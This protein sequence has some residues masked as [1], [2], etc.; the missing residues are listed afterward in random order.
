MGILI[1]HKQTAQTCDDNLTLLPRSHQLHGNTS[2]AEESTR[3]GGTYIKW[4]TFEIGD[5]NGN[6]VLSHLCTH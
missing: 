6:D 3:G 1:L 2:D 5:E 4:G